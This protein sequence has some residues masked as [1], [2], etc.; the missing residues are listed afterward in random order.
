[1]TRVFWQMGQALLPEHF[2]AQE[3]SLR[4]ETALRFSLQSLPSWG[5]GHIV[6]D[7]FLLGTGVLSVSELS[8]VFES[9]TVVDIPGNAGR[10]SMDLKA[11]GRTT[12][13]VYIQLDSG[14]DPVELPPI[15]APDEEGIERMVQ[16]LRLS[17]DPTGGEETFQLATM[18]SDPRGRWAFAEDHVP[19]LLLVKRDM[20]FDGPLRRME[21]LLKRLRAILGEELKE[22]HLSGETQLLA[23]Q[24]LRSLYSAQAMMTD[25]DAGIHPHPYDFFRALRQLYIDVCVYRDLTPD[26]LDKGYDHRLLGAA[27]DRLLVPVERTVTQGRRLRSYIEFTRKDGLISCA[28]PRDVKSAHD[29]LLLIEKPEI[30]TKLDLRLVKLASPK[31]LE[32]VHEHALT[33]VEYKVIAR[34]LYLQSFAPTVE[35]FGLARGLEWDYAVGE[36][37]LVLLDR[38]ELKGCRL[39]LYLREE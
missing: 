10:M 35:F 8:L 38:P 12:A 5:L 18:V 1:M 20:L 11:L 6:W 23:K 14:F 17:A 2:F 34:P 3:E 30:V 32:E 37:R 21:D 22:N 13:P 7:S 36:G 28:L 39:Y 27:F 25:L 15:G 19:P 24:A 33:G 26:G 31:R 4:A 29:V 9:G 16:R